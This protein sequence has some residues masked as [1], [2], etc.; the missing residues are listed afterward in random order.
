MKRCDVLFGNHMHISLLS[1]VYMIT[2]LHCTKW[3]IIHYKSNSR[4]L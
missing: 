4:S 2:H 3:Y 1:I